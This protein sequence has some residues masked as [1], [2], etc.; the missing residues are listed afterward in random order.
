VGKQTGRIFQL[1]DEVKVEI[2]RVNL[3][4]R[5]L[6]LILAENED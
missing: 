5:Q 1:G 4:K 2:A 3:A 6:D